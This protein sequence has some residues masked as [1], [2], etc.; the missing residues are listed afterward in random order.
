MHICLFAGMDLRRELVQAPYM[1]VFRRRFCEPEG[2]VSQATFDRI[3][4]DIVKTVDEAVAYAEGSPSPT[5]EDAMTHVY[6]EVC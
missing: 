3:E 2:L 6:A 4:A 1:P 5:A